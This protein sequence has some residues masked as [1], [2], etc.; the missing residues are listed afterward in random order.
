MNDNMP[1]Q[2]AGITL[3]QAIAK[4]T[5]KIQQLTE[6]KVA[7][8][9]GVT[10]EATGNYCVKIE[11]LERAGIPDTMD[12]IGLYEINLDPTGNLICYS[13]LGIRKRGEDYNNLN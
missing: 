1:K 3:E 8:V 10:P 13:R 11:V 5:K 7:G 12:L 9:V 4:A 2:G 6:L